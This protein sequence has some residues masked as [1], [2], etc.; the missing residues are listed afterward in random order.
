MHKAMLEAANE[1]YVKAAC[2][3]RVRDFGP[4]WIVEQRPEAVAGVSYDAPPDEDTITMWQFH[5]EVE[6]TQKLRDLVLTEVLEAA[7]GAMLK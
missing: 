3:W 4:T 1:A 5:T 7:I 6:A 2:K